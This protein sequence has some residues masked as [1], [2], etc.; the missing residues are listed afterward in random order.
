[1]QLVLQP[2]LELGLEPLGQIASVRQISDPGQRLG[3]A[4]P[5]V[6]RGQPAQDG[7]HQRPELGRRFSKQR[8]LGL[9]P[10]GRMAARSVVAAVFRAG[11]RRRADELEIDREVGELVTVACRSPGNHHVPDPLEPPAPAPALRVH[12]AELGQEWFGTGRQ[13]PSPVF[14]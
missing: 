7:A 12:P 9:E 4:K 6:V 13:V 14:R 11:H 3:M 10:Q 2:V 5:R 8:L 1:M